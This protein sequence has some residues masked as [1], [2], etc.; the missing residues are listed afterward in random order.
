MFR[1]SRVIGVVAALSL[2]GACGSSSESGEVGNTIAPTATTL[3]ASSGDDVDNVAESSA[4]TTLVSNNMPNDTTSDTTSD[5][6]NDTT[7]DMTN[8]TRSTMILHDFSDPDSVEGWNV[9][10]DTVMGGVSESGV[11]WL[12]GT[13]LFAGRVSLDNNGGF[14]S[15]RGPVLDSV[16]AGAEEL[17]V[18]AIGD[19]RTYVVQLLTDTDSYIRR[20]VAEPGEAEHLMPFD[21]FEATS[22]M[23]QPVTPTAPLMSQNIRQI[24]VY[25]LDKQEGEFELRLRSI[26]LR[27]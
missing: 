26:A 14:A 2:L 6:T 27:R 9:R 21:E 1:V 19:G 7:S 12:E 20:F 8:D 23:L 5:T 24:A 17:A 22:F 16:P 18:M 25:I 4:V 11:D 13:L 15:L 3:I 10:N